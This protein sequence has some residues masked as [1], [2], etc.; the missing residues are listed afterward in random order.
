MRHPKFTIGCDPEFFMR[1][2]TTGK[3]VSAIP[4]IKGTKDNPELL[5]KGGNIQR[6]NVS[7]E[8]ATDPAET[9]DQFVTNISH[10]LEEA[11][12]KPLSSFLTA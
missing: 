8:I 10:T 6:D 12:K 2:H 11:V 9:P 1:K 5:D 7:V 3:L 4:F